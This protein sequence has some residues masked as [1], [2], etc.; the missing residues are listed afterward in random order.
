MATLFDYLQQTQRFV[1]DQRQRIL[2]PEDLIEYVNRARREVAARTQCVRR[3]TTISGS[4]LSWSVTSGGSNY[5]SNTSATVTA[6]DF[7]SGAGVNPNGAQATATPVIQGG[8][9][10]GVNNDYGG[11]GYFQPVMSFTDTTGSGAAATADVAFINT[12]NRGQEV[13]NFSDVDLSMFPGVESCYAV[14]SVSIIYS[15]YRYSVP[16]YAFSVYQAMIRSYPFQ[17]QYVPTFCSQYGQGADGS[18]YMYP[19]PSQTYQLE[20]DM[21][22]LPQDL[23]DNQSV[24]VIPAPW[25]DVVPYFAAHLAYLELQNMNAGKFYLDLFDSMTLRKSQY[26]RVGRV[27]NPYGRY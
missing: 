10:V 16:M 20:W 13:Y 6:P 4:I 9:I 12:L 18:I 15:N 17:Y 19:L 25:D 27:V 2:D 1:R 26:A 23:T 8:V 5:T 22:C 7:P 14:K 21:F 11:A 24:D 3:L